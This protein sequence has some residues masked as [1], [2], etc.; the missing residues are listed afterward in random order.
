MTVREIKAK[1]PGCREVF[2]RYGM[3]GCGG[4]FGPPEPINFF[5]KAHNV[6]VDELIAD[7]KAAAASGAQA[8]RET[9]DEKLS[10]KMY[11]WFVKAAL[12]FTLTL[13]TVWGVWNLT[14][15]ALNRS[16]EIPNYSAVQGHG[17]AQTFGWVGLFVM[18]VAY[19]T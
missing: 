1:Y 14:V 13:G 11:K 17:H 7:L 18:G 12:L 5:A 8:A 9:D 2:T 10:G 3:G 15:I 6:S 19:Y 16:F 4:Q